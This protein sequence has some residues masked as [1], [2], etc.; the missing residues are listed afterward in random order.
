VLLLLPL[1][2]NGRA[3]TW[4]RAAA[5]E[6]RAAARLDLNHERIVYILAK[7]M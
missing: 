6:T 5:S 1:L 2:L 4:K 7:Y 3:Q